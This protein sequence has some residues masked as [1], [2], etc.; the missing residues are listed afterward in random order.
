MIVDDRYQRLPHIKPD[1][2]TIPT[3]AEEIQHA[4]K[5]M[6]MN[7]APGS[8]SVLTKMLSF[9]WRVS[10]GRASMLTNMV[11]NHGYL[12]EE[13]NK[14]IFISVSVQPWLPPRGI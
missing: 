9:H 12:P 10:A 1:T 4:L 13:F 8:D 2:A 3:I 14:S 6:P 5:R 11:Y 7:K